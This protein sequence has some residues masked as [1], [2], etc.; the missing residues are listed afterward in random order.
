M[1]SKT[2]QNPTKH[3]EKS[4]SSNID[5]KGDDIDIGADVVGGNKVV[6]VSNYYQNLPK[7][8][9]RSAVSKIKKLFTS[10]AKSWITWGVLAF[11][12][13]TVGGLYW[14]QQQPLVVC[15]QKNGN[16]VVL[17]A[18]FEAIGV[19]ERDLSRFVADDLNRKLTVQ[20]PPTN[21]IVCEYPK[22]I[23]SDEDALKIASINHADVIVW[24]NYTPDFIEAEVQV[25]E[26]S[27]LLI[28]QNLLAKTANVR[29]HMANE[30]QDSIARQVLGIIDI[31]IIA[32]GNTYDYIQNTIKLFDSEPTNTKIVSEG[33]SG[34][35]CKFV[36]LFSI[37][38]Q[39]ALDEINAAIEVDAGNPLL[40][41]MRAPALQRLGRFDESVDDA[42][43]GIRLGPKGWA[44]PIFF[45]ANQDL[46]A[47]N[48]DNAIQYYTQIIDAAAEHWWP[49]TMR[50]YLWLAKGDLDKAKTD[51]DKS[52][53][54]KPSENWPYMWATAIALRQGRL[55]DAKRYIE[56]AL[57][58]FPD[59]DAG[60][61]IADLV[62]GKNINPFTPALSAFW[63]MNLG[64]F[65]KAIQKAQIVEGINPKFT[66]AYLAEGVSYCN[67]GKLPEAEAA[68]T[69]AI[70][71]EPTFALL[72]LLRADVRAQQGNLADAVN[73]FALLQQSP[74][75]IQMKDYVLAAQ[76]GKISC[77]NILTFTP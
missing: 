37:D 7:S 25:G 1:P 3:K 43:T 28:P 35:V 33:V 57:N 56:D 68:Y 67:L 34:H 6:N 77:K 32:R 64:Q 40:Y 75:V 18:K 38:T 21:Y 27:N 51:I 59:A 50:G 46:F 58:Q 54:L 52:L 16:Y 63:S 17:V 74:Q 14:K 9:N 42:E 8:K 60:E 22:V 44:T 26:A 23:H 24:G 72:Y 13:L 29:V 41:M 12:I 71:I 30:R 11:I 49:Y 19:T 31:A 2:K 15:P 76:T 10:L 55:A 66:D 61:K 5:I 20:P 73:D 62:A 4:N 45:K 65:N 47:G 70:E 69:K 48:Y 53:A 39:K 36:E